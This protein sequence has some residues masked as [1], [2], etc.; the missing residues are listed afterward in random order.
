M[1]PPL[2]S[3]VTPKLVRLTNIAGVESRA[4]DPATF[5]PAEDHH[6]A[7]RNVIRWRRVE[8][9]DGT[10]KIE[11]NARFVRW[12]DGTTQLLVGDEVLGVSEQSTEGD[13]A[14]VY[15]RPVPGVMQA[16]AKVRSKLVFRPTNLDSK[17]HQR[18][19]R[20]IDRKHVKASKTM[21]HIEVQDPERAKE[22]ADRE[23]ERLMK[24]QEAL[25]KR[26]SAAMGR[27]GYG[28][29][30]GGA[31]VPSGYREYFDRGV[32]M[33]GDFL[34]AD[35]EDEEDDGAAEKAAAAVRAGGGEGGYDDEAAF[36]E[37][38]EEDDAAAKPKRKRGR[39]IEESD[40]E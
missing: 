6:E 8:R 20:A 38:V 35:E 12:S 17:T 36:D 29:G 31:R 5:E 27:G 18:L 16:A 19:T 37:D 23:A 2:P 28:G 14:F 34:E 9:P 15:A 7:N 11:S 3:H 21:M 4:F 13:N 40:S 10:V 30:R 39:A 25:K 26:Q 24:E 33:D 32:G 22:E 1:H